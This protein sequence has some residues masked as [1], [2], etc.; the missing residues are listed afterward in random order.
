MPGVFLGYYL[1]SG[2]RWY[3]DFLVAPLH[4][5]KCPPQWGVRVC[6]ISEVIFDKASPFRF[7]I[8]ETKERN[9]R[10]LDSVGNAD[11]D[12]THVYDNK[13]VLDKS[14]DD[15]QFLNALGSIINKDPPLEELDEEINTEIIQGLFATIPS[16][17]PVRIGGSGMSGSVRV[18]RDDPP[19]SNPNKVE[20]KGIKSAKTSIPLPGEVEPGDPKW[21][22]IGD[23]AIRKYK[24]SNRPSGIWPEVWQLTR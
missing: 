13:Q 1:L 4:D 15:E 12:Y 9:E 19:T 17:E 8:R 14:Q 2:E 7:P 16:E 20:G 3:G 23:R 21:E 11:I 18:A 6:R 22:V 5:F 24:G 10:S